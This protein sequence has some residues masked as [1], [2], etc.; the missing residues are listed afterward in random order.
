[1]ADCIYESEHTACVQLWA[2]I[3]SLKI[4]LEKADNLLQRIIHHMPHAKKISLIFRE[5]QRKRPERT[6]PTETRAQPDGI[7]I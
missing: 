6:N 4:Q 5:C 7:A 3:E 1:M 2:E